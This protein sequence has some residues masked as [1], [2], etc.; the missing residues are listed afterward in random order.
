VKSK[1]LCVVGWRDLKY[2]D[3]TPKLSVGNSAFEDWFQSQP[4]ATQVGIKQ[5]C[6]DS[7]AAGMGDPL[8]TYAAPRFVD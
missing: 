2:E 7:Y 3:S 6:R 8:V 1:E 5:M 4:F